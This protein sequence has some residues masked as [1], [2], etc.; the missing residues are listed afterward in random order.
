MD[1]ADRIKSITV[2]PAETWPVIEQEVT[3]LKT[4][5]V[6]YMLILA[7]IPAVASF[8]GLSLIGVG[9][10]GFTMRVPFLSGIGIMIT[11][12]IMTLV[13][14]GVWG[15]LI[16][17]LANTFGGQPNLMQAIKLTVYASTPGMLAGIFGI[18]PSLGILGL[19]GGLYSLYVLYLGLPVMMKNPKEKTIPYMVVAAV[20]GI[21]C[22]VLISVLAAIFTPS[23]MQ[24]MQGQ[25]GSG[26][27][28]IST[29]KGDVKITAGPSTSDNAPSTPGN[30]SMTIKTPDGEVTIDMKNME[31]LA[32]KMQAIADAQEAKK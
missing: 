23:P 31:E 1:I 28:N 6:P 7:A 9:G 17:M 15:W 30:S 21:V 13:M 11:Q 10:Y 20:V 27:I 5:Y 2:K 22:S 8:V 19:V 16:N 24:H 14:I 18:V 3:D 26:D 12:Y 25:G 4:L 29:P 32:K